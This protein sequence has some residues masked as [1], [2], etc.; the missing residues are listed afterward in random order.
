MS[1]RAALGGAPILISVVLA[2]LVA[3]LLFAL[4]GCYPPQSEDWNHLE[5]IA[6]LPT[7]RDALD[8]QLSHA[9]PLEYFSLWSLTPAGI[10]H[11]ALLRAP[12]FLMHVGIA[13]LVAAL[14]RSLGASRGHAVLAVALFLCFPAVKGLAWIMAIST[15]ARVLFMLAALVATVEHVKRPRKATGLALLAAQVLALAFHPSSCLLPAGVSMLAIATSPVRWRVLRDP[16][17]LLHVLLGAAYILL[18]ASLPEDQ[19][20]HGLRSIGAILAN[21]SRALLA[22]VP[23]LLRLPAIEGLRGQHGAAGTVFG[24]AVCGAAAALL[25]WAFWRGSAVVRALLLAAALDVV[26]PALTAGF[27]VRYAYFAAALVSVALALSA[28]RTRAWAVALLCLGAAWCYDTAV[29]TAEIREGA[30]TGLAVVEA[31]RAVRAEVGPDVRV[32]L[33][34]PPGEVGLE[35]DVPVFN[36]GL[37]A[38]LRGNG[39]AGPWLV[40]RTIPYVTS[41]DV[42]RVDAARLD[43]LAA[44]GVRIWRWHADSRRFVPR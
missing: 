3:G 35:R 23:E 9:R 13:G 15:P 4:T 14:A 34:D 7:W 1:Q 2:L 40:V 6:A 37:Q 19:R 8:T 12:L 11:P 17:L 38:A 21:S 36:W 31:A 10:E 43:Q 33:L 22:V 30:H 32:A 29:D 41:S 5:V 16:W 18:I 26:P 25:V 39:I 42:E 44:D 24:F 28:R 20:Y 27:V